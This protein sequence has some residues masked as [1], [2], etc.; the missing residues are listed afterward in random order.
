MEIQVGNLKLT[1]SDAGKP[2]GRDD[3]TYIHIEVLGDFS[4]KA[5]PVPKVLASELKAA[6]EA[7]EKSCWRP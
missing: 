2:W 5:K 6:I 3:E 1:A 7:L 4:G